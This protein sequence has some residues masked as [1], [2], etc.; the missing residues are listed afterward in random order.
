MRDPA[1]IDRML[2]KIRAIW[3]AY[4]DLRLGQLIN[5]AGNRGGWKDNDQFYVEDTLLE[6]GLDNLHLKEEKL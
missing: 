3:K 6:K 2:E 1:R 5:A 4:P